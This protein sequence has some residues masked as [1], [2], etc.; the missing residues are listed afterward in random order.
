MTKS[1]RKQ[2]NDVP[3]LDRGRLDAITGGSAGLARELV[4]MLIGE[5]RGLAQQIH[6]AVAEANGSRT[7][8]L[9][10]ALK[11]MAG[12]VGAV[13]L[14]HAAGDFERADVHDAP[15]LRRCVARLDE[16]LAV[17]TALR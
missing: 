11:G 5:A 15:G 9:V 10:H 16:E 12:N 13:R 1:P 2:M 7:A 4:T 3:V 14:Q 17:L 6:V 8:D